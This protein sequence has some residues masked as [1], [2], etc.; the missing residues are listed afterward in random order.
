M[1]IGRITTSLAQRR[2]DEFRQRAGEYGEAA[3]HLAYHAA[4]PVALNAELLH[5]LRINFFLD[6]PETLPY[7]AEFE[8]LLSPLCR[9]IDAGLYEIEPDV[10]DL[11]LIGL[12]Q[13][14]EP[15]RIREIATLLWQY[16]EQHSP[17]SDRIELE[18]AQQLTALNFLNPEKAQQWLAQESPSSETIEREWFVAMRQAIAHQTQLQ[19]DSIQSR[20][21]KGLDDRP[22]SDLARLRSTSDPAN[23]QIWTLQDGVMWIGRGEGNDVVLTASTASRQHA[24]ISYRYLENGTAPTYFLRDFSRYGT[25][26]QTPTSTAW[27]RILQQEVVLPSGTQLKFGDPRSEV[28]EF[29]VTPAAELEENSRQDSQAVATQAVAID[30]PSDPFAVES[31]KADSPEAVAFRDRET[32]DLAANYLPDI[33][34][35]QVFISYDRKDEAFYHQLVRHLNVLRQERVIAAWHDRCTLHE[36]DYNYQIDAFLESADLILFLISPDFLASLY[37]ETEV[38][39]ALERQSAGEAR[40]LP[41]LLRSANGGSARFD[42]QQILPSNGRP[43]ANWSNQDEAFAHI[44][45]NIREI[46]AQIAERTR[47]RSQSI[48]EQLSPEQRKRLEKAAA[49]LTTRD[50]SLNRHLQNLRRDYAAETNAANR[51][52]LQTQIEAIDLELEQLQAELEAIDQQL[53]DNPN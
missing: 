11:L 2:I 35:I 41:I 46:S 27:Q 12:T 51:L 50:T 3:L 42:A 28:L 10:R 29:T 20:R 44:A 34:P 13:T 21:R 14:Y 45:H 37:W 23:P 47:Q 30:Q 16:V 5:L 18:R 9:E 52:R 33:Q 31:Q 40:V 8:L 17:W 22:N 49:Q 48:S 32:Y 24:E 43:V 26:M 39:R 7:L 36:E 6:P 19:Q 53:L 4:L 1:T 25:W 15:Q 38:I